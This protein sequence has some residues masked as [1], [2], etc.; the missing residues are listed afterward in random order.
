MK[1]Y[2]VLLLLIFSI[3]LLSCH[4]K[5]TE[6]YI[7]TNLYSKYDNYL[8]REF[9]KIELGDLL[10]NGQIKVGDRVLDGSYYFINKTTI[11][12]G[13]VYD[14][15][16]HHP[17]EHDNEYIIFFEYGILEEIDTQ[18]FYTF[19][20]RIDIII[21]DKCYTLVTVILNEYKPEDF[22]SEHLNSLVYDYNNHVIS[23]DEYW[24]FLA[25]EKD[26]KL[27]IYNENCGY[28]RIKKEEWKRMVDLSLHIG[29][30]I[31]NYYD[32]A[33]SDKINIENFVLKE[34]INKERNWYLFDVIGV[35]KV[36][37]KI[38]NDTI[39]LYG[40]AI[41][42]AYYTVECTTL[43]NYSYFDLSKEQCIFIADEV[44][45]KIEGKD[46]F[47]IFSCPGDVE[48]K[49]KTYELVC[50]LLGESRPDERREKYWDF[51]GYIEEDKIQ[52]I[53]KDCGFL[54]YLGIPT[55]EDEYLYKN[56]ILKGMN[57]EESIICK[58]DYPI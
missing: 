9:I 24:D 30:T 4:N 54:K 21:N 32:Y 44:F 29:S 43:S 13:F 48:L 15:Q 6:E 18:V 2:M 1:K 57:V 37:E 11:T 27:I 39:T 31:S 16:P 28:M 5:P 55:T 51:A 20:N 26:G 35:S 23:Y 10:L 38:S 56:G 34:D 58:G 3:T 25:Y 41:D 47:I 36:K 46:L 52:F 49:E 40:K 33:R 12:T 45:S 17:T 50:N 53:Y 8:V 19:Q 42:G 22:K 14:S 7:S